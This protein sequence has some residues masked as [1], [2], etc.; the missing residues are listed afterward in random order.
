MS[1]INITRR[2]F[3]GMSA[4]AAASLG[5][6]ACGGQSTS[7]AAASTS[8]TA[9]A[10]KAHIRYGA[11]VNDHFFH[12]IALAK[13]YYDDENIEVEFVPTA[14]NIEAFT[15]LT[16]GK[17]DLVPSAGTNLPL[18]YIGNGENLTIFGRY[19]LTGCMP[20][21]AK[22]GTVWNGPED[23]IGKTLASSGNEF[24]VMGP[25]LDK[26][27]DPIHDINIKVMNNHSD[28]I[29]AV[30]Q[31]EADY[32]ILG[33]SM[34]LN[35]SKMDDVQVMAY[36]SDV[37]PDYS[38]CVVTANTDWLNNNKDAATRLLKAW[39]RAE[40]YYNEN[41]DE[42]KQIVADAADLKMDYLNAFADN[43]HFKITVDPYKKNIERAW[44]WMGRLGLL[45][46]DWQNTNLDDHI[47]TSMYKAALDECTQKYGDSNKS[48]YDFKNTNY[49]EQDA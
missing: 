32:A 19:M 46:G 15:S 47:D 42:C 39:M 23:L 16:S 29:E 26:G 33:T 12:N 30:R 8:S 17:I 45:K 11:K 48:F 6:A 1:N 38:C 2:N 7:G 25:L 9:P 4:L 40:Q 31:G 3:L 36:Q 5:L 44:D 22:T 35:I 13:G 20:I 27:Y 28:R 37:T 10:E 18:Q 14:D 24:A 41:K 43:P 34:N 21:I 49:T